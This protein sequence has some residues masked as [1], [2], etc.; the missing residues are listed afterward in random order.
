MSVLYSVKYAPKKL[1]EIIGNQ[2][3]VELIKQWMLQ[4]LSGKSRKPLLLYGPPGTGKTLM[5]QALGKEIDLPI[6]QIDTKR[7]R[8]ETPFIMV[9]SLNSTIK[10]FR[11][12]IVVVDEA[13]KFLGKSSMFEE[14]N[15]KDDVQSVV[16]ESFSFVED[17]KLSILAELC[18]DE[19]AETC[20]DEYH[21]KSKR[22]G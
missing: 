17:A 13:E 2:E 19:K 6:I 18:I 21:F 14:D 7:I 11:N 16:L 4:W 5:A 15:R 3:K 1:D 22:C 8:I 9:Q 20:F 12:C 10:K